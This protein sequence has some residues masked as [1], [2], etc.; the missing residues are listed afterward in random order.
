MLEGIGF[1]CTEPG[2]KDY[3]LYTLQRSIAHFVISGDL[4]IDDIC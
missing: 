4:S 3:S 1:E 2:G